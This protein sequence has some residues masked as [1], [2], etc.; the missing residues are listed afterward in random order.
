MIYAQE[1]EKYM[2]QMGWMDGWTYPLLVGAT[3]MMT[4]WVVVVVP[5]SAMSG[6][7]LHLQV[8]QAAGQDMIIR[9]SPLQE[10][11][12]SMHAAHRF[13]VFR[14]QTGI[15]MHEH[16][17]NLSLSFF[18]PI[19]RGSKN[20]PAPSSNQTKIHPQRFSPKR[21]TFPCK[22]SAASACT[23]CKAPQHQGRGTEPWPCR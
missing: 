23:P 17:G 7:I 5:C 20:P 4:V 22:L 6:Y 3:P 11:N 1:A 9:N 10:H 13:R 8:I 19:K 2:V 18:P 21:K 12:Y 15:Y 16:E 14:V